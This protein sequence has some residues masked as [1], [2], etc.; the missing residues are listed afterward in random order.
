MP[1]EARGPP[2]KLPNPAERSEV[3]RRLSTKSQT[4]S[5]SFSRGLDDNLP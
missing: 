3:D 4:A 2:I 5:S 1:L